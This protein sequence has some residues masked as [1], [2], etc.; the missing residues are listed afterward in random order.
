MLLAF[1]KAELRQGWPYQIILRRVI[2]M[3]TYLHYLPWLF[4][5][6]C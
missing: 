5:L 6:D 2:E 4:I 3:V 1:L